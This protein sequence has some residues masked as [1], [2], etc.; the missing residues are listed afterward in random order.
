MSNVSVQ[1]PA[2]KVRHFAQLQVWQKAHRLFLQLANDLERLPSNRATWVIADQLLRSVGA[3]SANIAEGFN[4]PTTKE[5]LRYLDTAKRSAHESENWLYKLR[6]LGLINGA[7]PE[8]LS[9]CDEI[10]RMLDGLSR[11]LSTKRR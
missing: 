6:D 5:Y 10:V 2:E 11:S 1:R 3:I 8:R 9:L 4:A 7:I